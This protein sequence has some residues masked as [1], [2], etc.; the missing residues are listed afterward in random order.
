VRQCPV[1][2]HIIK[3]SDKICGYCGSELKITDEIE[4]YSFKRLKSGTPSC[5]ELDVFF[6]ITQFS[7]VGST[8][9]IRFLVQALRGHIRDFFIDLDIPDNDRVN[10]YK[11]NWKP[12]P[13]NSNSL[14]L[15]INP[16]T[17][18]NPMCTFYIGFRQDNGEDVV[19][20]GGIH[21]KIFPEFKEPGQL[22]N[23]LKLEFRDSIKMGYGENVE[24][25]RG[26]GALENVIEKLKPEMGL[27]QI[28]DKVRDTKPEWCRLSLE[29][30]GYRPDEKIWKPRKKPVKTPVRCKI[31]DKKETQAVTLKTPRFR[32]HITTE[33]LVPFGRSSDNNRIVTRIFTDRFQLLRSQNIGISRWHGRIRIQP[34]QIELM[35]GG[36]RTDGTEKESK[37]GVFLNAVRVPFGNPVTIDP[38]KPSELQFSKI[39]SDPNDTMRLLITPWSCPAKLCESCDIPCDQSRPAALVIKRLDTVPEVFVILR[40]CLEMGFIHDSLR[41]LMIWSLNGHICYRTQDLSGRLVDTKTIDMA[42]M[43][44]RIEKWRQYCISSDPDDKP[45]IHDVIRWANPGEWMQWLKKEYF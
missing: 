44:V 12:K 31:P 18:G 1:C 3:V 29:P 26:S 5:R 6:D 19:Y 7:V 20:E 8:F 33:T 21:Q 23:H 32:V 37:E 43:P 39:N 27:K 42:G 10:A 22:I 16:R 45:P 17:P 36:I 28:I 35:D 15:H 41:G 38:E 11:K 2:Q 25:N 4:E 34:S 30:S 13:G 40:R 24:M 9:G 14:Y